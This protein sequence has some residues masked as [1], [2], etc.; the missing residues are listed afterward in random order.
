LTRGYRSPI[1]DFSSRA[2]K[3]GTCTRGAGVGPRAEGQRSP[4]AGQATVAVAPGRGRRAVTGGAMG[5]RLATE[6]RRQLGGGHKKECLAPCSGPTAAALPL[7][8]AHGPAPGA[9]PVSGYWSPGL[10]RRGNGCGAPV[11]VRVSWAQRGGGS[12]RRGGSGDGA[13]AGAV[14]PRAGATPP[15]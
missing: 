13:G 8:H 10:D 5:R 7:R 2:Q 14:G 12:P 15:L 1:P 11:P 6:V 3:R 4:A 9:I